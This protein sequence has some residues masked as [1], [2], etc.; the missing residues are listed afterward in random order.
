MNIAAFC[1]YT[2]WVAVGGAV[3]A[4]LRFWSAEIIHVFF[5]KGFPL[6][7]FFVNVLG[8]FLMGYLATLLFTETVGHSSLR[9]FLLIGLLGAFTTFS[10]FSLDTVELLTTGKLGLAAM[11]VTLSVVVCISMAWVGVLVA[12]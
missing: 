5:E 2:F 12:S 10:T 11:N 1:K 9:S 3:G 4:V 7:T 8:S 6:G